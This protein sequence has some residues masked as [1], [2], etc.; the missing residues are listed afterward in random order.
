MLN[1]R[2]RIRGCAV[3]LAVCALAGC[4]SYSGSSLKPGVAT[5]ADARTLMGAPV[6]VHPAPAGS[7]HTE[8][9]EYP[10]GPMGRDTFML[11]FDAEGRLL[12]IDQVL[13]LT[14]VAK[15][16]IGQDKREDV[17]RLL[18]RPAMIYPARGGGTAWDY[19]AYAEGGRPRKVRLSVTFD[20]AGVAQAAG[21]SVDPEERSSRR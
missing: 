3:V 19:A 7:A 13:T 9:W 1:R 5:Q 2:N 15:I 21:E 11:R 6:A 18:G 20:A 14:Y 8:S 4:A 10:R 12:A 16:R 17:R